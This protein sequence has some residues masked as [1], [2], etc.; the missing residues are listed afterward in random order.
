MFQQVAPYAV[1]R[2]KQASTDM[3]T[4]TASHD[5]PKHQSVGHINKSAIGASEEPSPLD[6]RLYIEPNRTDSPQSSYPVLS[7]GTQS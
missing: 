5:S 4:S 3:T 1:N 7:S 6:E 2:N